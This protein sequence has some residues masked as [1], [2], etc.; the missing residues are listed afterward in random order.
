M[1][2]KKNYNTSLR[3]SFLFQDREDVHAMGTG[4]LNTG[5]KRLW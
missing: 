2:F 1:A 5:E 4:G 3:E